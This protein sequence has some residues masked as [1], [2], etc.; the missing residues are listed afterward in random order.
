M[1]EFISP[2]TGI[3]P[4][5]ILFEKQPGVFFLGLRFGQRALKG[6]AAAG[7]ELLR[8]AQQGRLRRFGTGSGNSRLPPACGGGETRSWNRE[9]PPEAVRGKIGRSDSAIRR[10][11]PSPELRAGSWGRHVLAVH[12]DR[13]DQKRGAGHQGDREHAARRV[14][15]AVADAQ[16]ADAGRRL[17]G[18]RRGE[19]HVTENT[20][21]RPPGRG[22]PRRRTPP[23]GRSRR[24]RKTPPTC[25]VRARRR[26]ARSI[27]GA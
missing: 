24:S 26:Q 1:T 11:P 21:R 14:A 6:K 23:A 19:Q 15:R 20:L 12:G 18:A 2:K 8:R 16:P 25:R 7:D 27:S 17:G 13:R 5:K 22:S 4:S 3:A 9:H 10:N